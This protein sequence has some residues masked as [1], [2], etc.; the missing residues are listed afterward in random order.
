MAKLTKIVV[1]NKIKHHEPIP[2]DSK[3]GIQIQLVQSNQSVDNWLEVT[4]PLFKLDVLILCLWFAIFGLIPCL[5]SC[6]YSCIAC[7]KN[8]EPKT[9]DFTENEMNE[10]Q[11]AFNS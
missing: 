7:G 5:A 9:G 10:S 1:K 2:V 6:V 4:E 8:E 11:R 3:A